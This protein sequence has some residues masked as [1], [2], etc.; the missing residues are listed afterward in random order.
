MG[1][2]S[3]YTVT[4]SYKEVD[5]AKEELQETIEAAKTQNIIK[6]Y[7]VDSSDLAAY[8][9][10]KDYDKGRKNPFD[11]INVNSTTNTST[12][13]SSSSSSKSN[14]NSTTNTE[15]N[16]VSENE[17]PQ[18]SNQGSFFNEVKWKNLQFLVIFSKIN[19]YT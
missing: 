13:S 6:T 12:S 1:S 19:I 9:R 2:D 18:N 8:A 10:T 4:Y 14:S 11:P 15:T 5:T 16:T 17:T 3:S 7:T